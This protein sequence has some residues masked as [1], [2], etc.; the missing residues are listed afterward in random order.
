MTNTRRPDRAFIVT[1]LLVFAASSAVTV[2]W[3]SSMSAMPGMEMPGGW[4]MSMTWMR[5]PGQSWPGAAATF[6]GMWTVMMV[7]MMMPVLAPSLSRYR[8][9]NRP[10]VAA[11]YFTVW[12]LSGAAVYPLGVALAEL[13]MRVPALSR[14]IPLATGVVLAVAGALQFTRW[15]A[16]QLACCRKSPECAGKPGSS[17]WRTGWRLGVQCL[18]CCLGPTA[19]L[20]VVGVMDLRAMA[21]TAIA[22]CAERLAPRGQ[23]VA[24]VI[25][26]ILIA[27]ALILIRRSLR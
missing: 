20:L 27:A 6:L 22:I 9:V 8:A 1:A 19:V 15:K 24:R 10:L 12:T 5:M 21:V 4:T 3:C 14:G 23:R 7:A 17:A 2:A 18:R 16:R 13:A 26:S 25:G 11:G